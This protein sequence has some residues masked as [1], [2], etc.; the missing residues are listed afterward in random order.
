MPGM[1]LKHFSA[2]DFRCLESVAFEVDPDYNL[3]YGANAS[4]KTSVLEAIAYLGRG[5]SFRRASADRVIRHGAAEFLLFG[6]VLSGDRESA[7]GVRNGAEGLEVSVDGD[8][9]GGMAALASVLPLQVIDPDIHNLVAGG[10]EER[11]RYLDWMA[12]HV[13]RGY[14]A[15]WRNYRRALRQRNAALRNGSG[16]D[17]LLGWDRPFCELAEAIGE[18]RVRVLEKARVRLESIGER[19]IGTTVG[20]DYQ[21]G[22]P[23][24]M[25]LAEALDRNRE[26]DRQQGSSQVGPQRADLALSTDERRARKVVSRGQQKLLACTLVLAATGVV[27]SQIGRRL[28]LLLDDPAAELD[29]GALARLMGEVG[30]LGSQVIATSLQPDEA[31]FPKLPARFHVEQG[32]LGP[33]P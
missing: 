11:R 19:L 32:R 7:V 30:V 24:G 5:K 4:G 15:L 17:T 10:P 14:L 28:L 8:R 23:R 26:R 18:A 22:W 21:Q 3:I 29:S 6:R 27:Q 33:V 1:T 2:T 20:F 31:L 25:S 9:S 13:E 12:F 16:G